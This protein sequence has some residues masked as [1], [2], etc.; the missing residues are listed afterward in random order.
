MMNQVCKLF[1]FIL[2]KHTF[3]IFIY[4]YPYLNRPIG[5]I[6]WV[7]AKVPGDMGSILGGVIL[8]TQK[9]VL[10][11]VLLIPQHYN[12]QI[13]GKWSNPGKRV[14]PFEYTLVY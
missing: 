13:N 2:I 9:M 12:V 7:F 6:I 4:S 10:D 11:A 14:E 5:I 3:V 8:K 1:F